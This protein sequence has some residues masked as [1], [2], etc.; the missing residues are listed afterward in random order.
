[1]G[2]FWHRKLNQHKWK[3][4]K[5]DKVDGMDLHG[6]ELEYQ[7]YGVGNDDFKDLIMKLRSGWINIHQECEVCGDRRIIRK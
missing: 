5:E 6:A 2:L 1:M 7:G 4:V 3:T